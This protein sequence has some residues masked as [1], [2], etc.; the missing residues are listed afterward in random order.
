MKNMGMADIRGFIERIFKRDR[1]AGGDQAQ[2]AGY[3]Q[4]ELS[5]GMEY[6]V[7]RPPPPGTSPDEVWGTIE[8]RVNKDGIV[9]PTFIPNPGKGPVIGRDLMESSPP[10]PIPPRASRLKN[11]GGH[12]R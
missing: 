8:D 6:T 1:Q 4:S 11:S 10:R 2:Q 3:E 7:T 9:V 12:S 5:G